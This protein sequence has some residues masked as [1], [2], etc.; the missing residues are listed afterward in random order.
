MQNK[1]YFLD[2]CL[3]AQ[4]EKLKRERFFL[5]KIFLTQK[6]C[7]PKNFQQCVASMQ[8]FWVQT[9]STQRLPSPNFFKLSVPG[10]LRI[11]RAFASLFLSNPNLCNCFLKCA[12]VSYPSFW[13]VMWKSHGGSLRKWKKNTALIRNFSLSM[14]LSFFL[15]WSR[16]SGHINPF[17]RDSSINVILF[18]IP[19]TFHGCHDHDNVDKQTNTLTNK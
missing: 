11:F 17:L 5:P 18:P 16:F 15:S 13:T 6:L 10:G 7:R 3:I 8:V 1:P 4:R 19:P 14:F 9:F 12:Q 2:A